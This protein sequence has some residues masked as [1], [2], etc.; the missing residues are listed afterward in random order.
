MDPIP[1]INKTLQFPQES[2]HD[3]PGDFSIEYTSD[4]E[5][6][7]ADHTSDDDLSTFV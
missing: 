1:T 3:V 2:A 5:I 6:N 4:D 7:N